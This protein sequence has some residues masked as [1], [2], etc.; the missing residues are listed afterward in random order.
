MTTVNISLPD[1]LK[2]QADSLVK[3][4]YYASFSDLMRDGA[5]TVIRRQDL[6]EDLDQSQKQFKAGKGKQLTSLKDLR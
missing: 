2:H 4:G 3:A 6:L 1:K 5:R